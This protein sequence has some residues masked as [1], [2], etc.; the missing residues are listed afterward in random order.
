[1]ARISRSPAA[2][3]A[4]KR[5]ALGAKRQPIA[6]VLHI[7]SAVQPAFPDDGR[8]DAKLRIR[9][10]GAARHLPRGEASL[11]KGGFSQG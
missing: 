2:T 5:R 10:V 6:G 3:A 11:A 4:E 8:A 7:G 9:R 1:M